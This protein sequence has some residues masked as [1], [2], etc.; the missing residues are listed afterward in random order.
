V[1]LII[2][3]FENVIFSLDKIIYITLYLPLFLFFNIVSFDERGKEG[4]GGR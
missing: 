1:V 3:F 4:L 2:I